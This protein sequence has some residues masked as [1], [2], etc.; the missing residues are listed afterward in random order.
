MGRKSTRNIIINAY[1][2]LIIRPHSITT[3]RKEL[4]CSRDVIH[5]FFK[6][7]KQ[8]N[9]VYVLQDK[10][11]KFYFLKKINVTANIDY[12]IKLTEIYSNDDNFLKNCL[13]ADEFLKNYED[14]KF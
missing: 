8:K 14:N 3:L 7:L 10:K 11:S 9:L 6:D 12:L 2:S 13:T 1:S 5:Y 4:G